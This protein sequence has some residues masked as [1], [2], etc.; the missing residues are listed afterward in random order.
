MSEGGS[1]PAWGRVYQ[2]IVRDPALS[3]EAKG[4]YAYLASFADE[5]GQC[6][7]PVDTIRQEIPLSNS[8]YY[9]Y[10]GE[11]RDAGILSVEKV[12]TGNRYE[13]NIY[14]LLIPQQSNYCTVQNLD[15]EPQKNE[16]HVHSKNCTIQHSKKCTAKQI[17]STDHKKQTINRERKNQ[18]ESDPDRAAA[19]ETICTILNSRR[20]KHSLKPQGGMRSLHKPDSFSW[21]DMIEA[22]EDCVAQYPHPTE[23]GQNELIGWDALN[24]YLRLLLA[25]DTADFPQKYE[26]HFFGKRPEM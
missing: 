23:K 12:R 25:D 11:L 1:S 9:K 15:G 2:Q 20:W 18:K 17:K 22:A 26:R 6:Y 5:K 19:V 8:T 4:L 3:L 14:H 10:V 13:S 24:Y 21:A 7:P 16:L